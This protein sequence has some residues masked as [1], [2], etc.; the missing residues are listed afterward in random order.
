MDVILNFNNREIAVLLWID[1]FLIFIL[2]RENLK[3]SLQSVFKCLCSIY[4]WGP[5]LLGTIWIGGLIWFLYRY[6]IWSLVNAKTTILWTFAFAFFSMFKVNEIEFDKSYRSQ[7]IKESLGLAT[8]LLFITSFYTLPLVFEII[9]LPIATFLAVTQG[10]VKYHPEYKEV[11]KFCTYLLSIIGFA[12]F[13]YATLGIYRHPE[14]LFTRENLFEFVLSILLTLWY[15]PYLFAW[16]ILLVYEKFGKSLKQNLKDPELIKFS[17][18]A[19]IWHLKWDIKAIERIRKRLYTRNIANRYEFMKE[20]YWSR[21]VG[22]RD[23]YHQKDNKQLGWAPI[24]ARNFL[25]EHG[26]AVKE[27]INMIGD[28]WAGSSY[29]AVKDSSSLIS[30][31]YYISGNEMYVREFELTMSLFPN[32]DQIECEDEFFKVVCKLTLQAINHIPE[33]CFDSLNSLKPFTCSHENV[34]KELTIDKSTQRKVMV[35]EYRFKLGIES[36]KV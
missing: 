36:T 26:L 33:N 22:L 27:Y 28:D 6:G 3:N 25:S 7:L 5:L 14:S 15:L 10:Y 32:E 11:G 35:I 8:I 4:I 18:V 16:K 2:L 17:R 31:S 12:Y 13:L 1:V 9:L 24:N 30:I 20:I 34:K 29:S 23:K 19:I 21:L